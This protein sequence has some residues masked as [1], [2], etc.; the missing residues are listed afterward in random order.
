MTVRQEG[1]DYRG[2]FRLD[3]TEAIGGGQ[4]SDEA[5]GELQIDEVFKMS[6]ASEWLQVMQ[7]AF[8]NAL[9]QPDG[10]LYNGNGGN[11]PEVLSADGGG[12]YEKYQTTFETWKV[13]LE[14]L[15]LSG[16]AASLVFGDMDQ[17]IKELRVTPIIKGDAI[18]HSEMAFINV[19]W[20]PEEDFRLK[21]LPNLKANGFEVAFHFRSEK[22]FRVA[23]LL[24]KAV[25]LA[26]GN[27]MFDSGKG[28]GA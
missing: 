17:Y 19:N 5:L 15:N 2:D 10:R 28:P 11:N 6:K 13:L 24:G 22:S 3:I 26:S 7:S 14:K 21:V 23:A 1:E 25:P 12:T 16:E 4:E 20:M 8:P 27:A 9:I 18:T